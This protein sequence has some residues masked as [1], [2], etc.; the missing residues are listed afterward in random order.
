MMGLVGIDNPYLG[1][2]G[3]GT[4]GLLDAVGKIYS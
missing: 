3:G 4:S 2:I 1:I